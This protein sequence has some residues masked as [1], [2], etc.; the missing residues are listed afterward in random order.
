MKKAKET[1]LTSDPIQVATHRDLRKHMRAICERLN[2]QP[3][4]AR[5]V[6]VNPILALED[7]GVSLEPEAKQHIMDAL[8]FPPKLQKRKAEL[9]AELTEAFAREGVTAKFPLTSKQRAHLVFR[10]LAI[11]PLAEDGQAPDSLASE[12]LGAYAQAH[13]LAAKLAEYERLDRGRMIFQPRKT[14]DL[15][16]SGQKRHRWIKSVR[17]KI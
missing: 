3:D 5:L 4:I 12:R 1:G 2:A 8:R 9:A 13:P 11:A 7:V 16:K 10:T 6:F 17:F 14:Y 15:Y